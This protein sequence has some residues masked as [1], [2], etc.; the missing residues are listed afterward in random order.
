MKRLLIAILLAG[1]VENSGD[2]YVDWSVEI[3]HMMK[4][5]EHQRFGLNIYRQTQNIDDCIE[6]ARGVSYACFDALLKY[7]V[8]ATII[9]G[10]GY[11]EAPQWHECDPLIAREVCR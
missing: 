11:T 5:T 4:S 2:D 8:C 3:C 9:D 6:I 1:C 10:N 7:W